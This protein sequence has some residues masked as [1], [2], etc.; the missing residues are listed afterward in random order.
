MSGDSQT[1]PQAGQPAELPRV[2][3]GSF[4][5]NHVPPRWPR[6]RFGILPR[7]PPGS[8]R[9]FAGPIGVAPMCIELSKNS[10]A[11]TPS[12]KSI[13]NLFPPRSAN[14]FDRVAIGHSDRGLDA[15]PPDLRVRPQPVESRRFA[16]ARSGSSDYVVAAPPD[17][18]R[19]SCGM[20]PE[21]SSNAHEPGSIASDPPRL[22]AR[23]KDA[24]DAGTVG[25]GAGRGAGHGSRP[26]AR[27]PRVR[28]AYPA[29]AGGVRVPGDDG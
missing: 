23:P 24:G 27:P 1:G 18:V 8:F 13:A 15:Q 21:A 25:P 6:S 26:P 12:E 19:S 10:A 22:P 4:R 11:R 5:R 16:L 9:R 7:I 2:P 28:H 17:R 29:W 14:L 3:L 20:V